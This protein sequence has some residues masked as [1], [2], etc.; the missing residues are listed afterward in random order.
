MLKNIITDAM[1]NVLTDLRHQL[2]LNPEAHAGI[3]SN[4]HRHHGI[5]YNT[6]HVL[7][8]NGYIH[9]Q[10]EELRNQHSQCGSGQHQKQYHQHL[11][12][13][14][15]D[16]TCQSFQLVHIKFIFQDFIYIIFITCHTLTPPFL[17]T[18]LTAVRSLR[19]DGG[20]PLHSS[21]R[22]GQAL[23][24]CPVPQFFPDP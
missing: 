10:H 21:R 16:I 1:Y 4:N 17:R 3:K 13:V 15:P 24:V 19:T 2:D 12:L 18:A 7:I 6:S 8:G 23:H 11:L 9:H 5:K 20:R 22:H 14:R